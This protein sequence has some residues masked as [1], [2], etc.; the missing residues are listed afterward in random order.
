MKPQLKVDNPIQGMIEL[1]KAIQSVDIEALKALG[2]D[3]SVW[4]CTNHKGNN[5]FHRAAMHD[6]SEK[7]FKVLLKAISHDKKISLLKQTNSDDHTPL[8][9][10]AHNGEESLIE[11]VHKALGEDAKDT[12]KLNYHQKG[13]LPIHEAAK[14]GKLEAIDPYAK[15]TSHTPVPKAST[16]L[17]PAQRLFPLESIQGNSKHSS[18]SSASR[19]LFHRDPLEDLGFYIPSEAIKLEHEV[20]EGLSGKIYSGHWRYEKVAVKQS[21][22]Q[23]ALMMASLHSNYI[24]TLKGVCHSPMSYTLVMEYMCGGSL[25]QVLRGPEMLPWSERHNIASDVAKG[26]AFLHNRAPMIIHRD[27]KS[28]NILLTEHNHAKLADFG[29]AMEVPVESSSSK[30]GMHADSKMVGSLPWMAPECFNLQYSSKSDMYAYGMVLWEIVSRQ[31][32]YDDVENAEEIYAA[33]QH[34]KQEEIPDQ[35]SQLESGNPTAKTPQSIKDFIRLCWFH[36]AAKRPSADDAVKAFKEDI[37]KELEEN[38]PVQLGN[39]V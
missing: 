36:D 4:L 13:Y 1:F 16:S 3:A 18:T 12:L 28:H 27:I 24:V 2:K 6:E 35:M 10:L 19:S 31:R 22:L 23:E 5:V 30:Y 14:S 8:D 17:L 20:G 29:L 21:D 15:R 33:V 34:G 37:K 38:N 7:L 32:P 26:L 11:V 39:A 9:I 25:T